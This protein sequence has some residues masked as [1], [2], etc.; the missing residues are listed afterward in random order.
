M[1]RTLSRLKWNLRTLPS[2]FLQWAED[3]ELQMLSGRF[4]KINETA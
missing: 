1:R 2:R 3:V 4:N